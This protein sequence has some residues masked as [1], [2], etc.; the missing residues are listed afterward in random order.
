MTTLLIHTK[1]LDMNNDT[2]SAS[3]FLVKEK[4][5]KSMWKELRETEEE[6]IEMYIPRGHSE[7]AVFF[8]YKE[9]KSSFT[10]I[11]KNPDETEV[12]LVKKIMRLDRKSSFM[13]FFK[14]IFERAK[15]SAME[16]IC[17][18]KYIDFSES[19]QHEFLNFKNGKDSD[20]KQFKL[21]IKKKE[22]ERNK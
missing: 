19:L 1:A 17:R 21:F 12:A 3:T 2:R 18:E 8:K 15:D 22:E 16:R 20:I 6:E 14:E 7:I 5:W 10:I 13:N 9:F 4:K 11:K